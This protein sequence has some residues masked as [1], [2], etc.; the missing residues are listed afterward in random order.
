MRGEFVRAAILLGPIEVS[1]LRNSGVSAFQGV[2]LYVSLWSRRYVL[3]RAKC[4]DYRGC[5]HFRG[6]GKAGFHCRTFWIV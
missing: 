3:D 6:V 1:A 5:P 2:W 4:P